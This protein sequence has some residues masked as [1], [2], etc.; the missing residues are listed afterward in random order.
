M[1]KKNFKGKHP[2]SETELLKTANKELK[3]LALSTGSEF[4]QLELTDIVEDAGQVT[5]IRASEA[6][7]QTSN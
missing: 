7:G 5:A 3:V 4:E 1:W 6:E 2:Q